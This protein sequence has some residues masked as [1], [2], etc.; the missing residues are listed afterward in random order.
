MNQPDKYLYLFVNEASPSSVSVVIKTND[1]RSIV[2]DTNLSNI[3]DSKWHHYALTLKNLGDDS[4]SDL[5]VD[6]T[7]ISVKRLR[8]AGDS[9][10][11]PKSPPGFIVATIWNISCATM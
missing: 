1:A 6:G 10:R 3:A 5:Y 7:H 9:S 4:I 11:L 2:H 8:N